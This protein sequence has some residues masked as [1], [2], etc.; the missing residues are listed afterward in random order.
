MQIANP[1]EKEQHP[2]QPFLPEG[3]KILMLGSFPPPKKRWCMDF[4]YPN[5]G[6]DMWRIWGHIAHGDK[7][8]FVVP[9]EKRFDKDKITAFC[10]TQGIALY[11]TAEEVVRLK[12]NAS[13]NFLQVERPTDLAA[14]LEQI[15]DCHTIVATGQKSA[16]TLQD[17]MGCAPL[18]VGGCVETDFAGRHITVWRMPS[19]SR[20][21]PRPVEW[22]AAF[23]Q[24]V[25]ETL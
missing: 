5:W 9:G 10:R 23:Y 12:G 11:D 8:F 25:L 20:A 7:N 21:Y 15:P 14:L 1:M 4:F 13:D 6:N 2:L 18:P 16:E 24:K 19:S 22:K 3:A 17:I